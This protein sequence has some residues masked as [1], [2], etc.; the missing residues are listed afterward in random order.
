[1]LIVKTWCKASTGIRSTNSVTAR[2]A[3]RVTDVVTVMARPT[4]RARVKAIVNDVG[5]IAVS[6][7]AIVTIRL[8]LCCHFHP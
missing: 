1:M 4:N 3:V 5:R 7:W 8:G 6:G 2:A